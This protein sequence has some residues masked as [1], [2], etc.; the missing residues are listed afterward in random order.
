MYHA[1]STAAASLYV[2]I[3]YN[4]HKSFRDADG[5]SKVEGSRAVM[6]LSDMSLTRRGDRVN[7]TTGIV[8][9]V[10]YE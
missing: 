10:V 4:T 3:L 9:K 1:S 2:A 7:E 8:G 5:E 6:R